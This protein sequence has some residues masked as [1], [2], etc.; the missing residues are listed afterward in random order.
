MTEHNDN[1]TNDN[2][3]LS[4]SILKQLQWIFIIGYLL[5]G[6]GDSLQGSYRYALY[7]SYQISRSPIELLY[8]IS[9]GSS[10]FIGTFAASLAD[11]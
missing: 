8:V 3:S 10:L 9:Y 7:D 2:L 5:V 4:S 1:H 11:R 6:V